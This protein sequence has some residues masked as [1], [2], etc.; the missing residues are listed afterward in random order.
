MDLLQ[1]ADF[2]DVREIRILPVKW[3][4]YHDACT[5]FAQSY[6][7]QCRSGNSPIDTAVLEGKHFLNPKPVH[8]RLTVLNNGLRYVTLHEEDGKEIFHDDKAVYQIVGEETGKISFDRDPKL[9]HLVDLGDGFRLESLSCARETDVYT[10][11]KAKKL[12]TAEGFPVTINFLAVGK[13]ASRKGQLV[14][15]SYCVEQEP[16]D[17]NI[18][19]CFMV[20][21]A[22]KKETDG[23]ISPED[24]YISALV[25]SWSSRDGQ[26]FTA[27]EWDSEGN[28]TKTVTQ[29]EDGKRAKINPVA[30]EVFG[31]EISGLRL[32]ARASLNAA[33]KASIGE[34]LFRTQDLVFV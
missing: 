29:G 4:S 19:H 1:T 15:F 16:A 10:L 11:T 9:F 17:D 18:R 28:P 8:L 3:D 23:K 27:F 7:D 2:D 5:E 14:R 32:D 12:F 6:V 22:D 20:D 34:K 24:H 26:Y 21:E 25:T 33:L 31:R 30:S 13:N